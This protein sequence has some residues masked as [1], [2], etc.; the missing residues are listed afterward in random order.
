VK[1]L[2]DKT[3]QQEILTRLM[4]LS[5]LDKGR[6][7]VMTVHQMLCHL[8]DAYLVALG[9]KTASPATGLLQRTILKQIAL[10]SPLK[11]MKGFPTRPELEQGRGGTPPTDFEAD[12][13]ALLF[14]FQRFCKDLPRPCPPHPVFG[15][16]DPD[17]WFRWGHLHADHHLRQ[18]GV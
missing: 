15:P 16:M 3:D 1:T 14:A 5:P 10:H 11:W 6:W 8:S 4:L 9:E 18:F 12:R 17:D 7:G 13:S 2:R